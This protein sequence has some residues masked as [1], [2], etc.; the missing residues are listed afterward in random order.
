M[1]ERDIWPALKVV[2]RG[3]KFTALEVKETPVDNHQKEL[4]R[5][6]ANIQVETFAIVGKNPS[7]KFNNYI[8]GG[9]I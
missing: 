7:A 2:A 8:W 1:I 6:A 9:S 3:K 5:R 4:A